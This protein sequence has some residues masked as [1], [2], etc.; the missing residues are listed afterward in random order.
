[1]QVVEEDITSHISHPAPFNLFASYHF[2]F[3][4]VKSKAGCHRRQLACLTHMTAVAAI[5]Y[6]AAGAT[7][8]TYLRPAHQPMPFHSA[9]GDEG[10]RLG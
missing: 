2:V 7:D 6:H 8:L 10:C 9:N 4:H 5:Y 1:M 3:W